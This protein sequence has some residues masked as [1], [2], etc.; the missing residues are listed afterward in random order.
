MRVGNFTSGLLLVLLILLSGCNSQGGAGSVVSSAVSDAENSTPASVAFQPGNVVP[1]YLP[2]NSDNDIFLNQGGRIVED[3]TAPH[4][5]NSLVL[6]ASVSPSD[7]IIY[8]TI[9][10]DMEVMA[11]HVF[12]KVA[13]QFID[14]SG[15]QFGI[16][17][18]VFISGVSW[19]RA[20][21]RRRAKKPN[22][23]PTL[24]PIPGTQAFI[25]DNGNI[26]MF[27]SGDHDVVTVPEGRQETT[28]IMASRSEIANNMVVLPASFRPS[29]VKVWERED[30]YALVVDRASS[31]NLPMMRAGRK[32]I[33]YGPQSFRFA[34][35][36]VWTRDTLFQRSRHDSARPGLGSLMDDRE[37]RL[38][39][40]GTGRKPRPE[41]AVGLGVT[42]RGYGGGDTIVYRDGFGEM[43]VVEEDIS[44]HAHNT[45]QMPPGVAPGDVKFVIW[46]TDYGQSLR[47][48][49]FGRDGVDL[50]GQLGEISGREMGVQFVR[51]ADGTVWNKATIRQ[52][53]IEANISLPTTSP[54]GMGR[55]F[56]IDTGVRDVT[57]TG[58]GDV[59]VYR[60]IVGK[61][62][63]HDSIK[64]PGRKNVL[65]LEAPILPRMV[66]LTKG[67]GDFNLS[68][69]KA[70]SIVIVDGTLSGGGI[71]LIEFSDGTQWNLKDMNRIAA[72]MP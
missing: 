20:E 68:I 27:G 32:G 15:H 52:K 46:Q 31:I 36:T 5:D 58:F 50:V 43:C 60:P 42:V 39:D 11:P 38:L 57:G 17:R 8:E 48:L 7:V 63:I 65:K 16:Q 66:K 47:L 70:S 59:I 1:D 33:T 6:P 22:H 54:E 69:G 26:A 2:G 37:G 18:L 4:P 55:R 12:V 14:L 44:G 45:L 34:D 53:A 28:V 13:W 24:T 61:V 72:Q 21:L 67:Y 29:T 9:D 51:F 56:I 19:T 41:D 49:V 64:L 35:G 23:A 40:L 3:S 25:R 10:G 62:T 30:G 71:Q